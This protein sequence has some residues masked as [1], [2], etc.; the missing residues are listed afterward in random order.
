MRG[1]VSRIHGFPEQTQGVDRRRKVGH[2]DFLW[3]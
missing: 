1:L 3:R 2:D